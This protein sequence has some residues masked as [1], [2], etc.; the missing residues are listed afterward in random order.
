MGR[1]KEFQPVKSAA[2]GVGFGGGSSGFGA[3]ATGFGGGS[4]GF[5]GAAHPLAS[6]FSDEAIAADPLTAELQQHLKRLAKKDATTKRK[7]LAELIALVDDTTDDGVTRAIIALPQWCYMYA[8]LTND[9]TV[10][11]R[12]AAHTLM[13]LVARVVKAELEPHIPTV[14][15]RWW[16]AK[17][18]PRAEA[19][20]S[21]E[22]ALLATFP[23]RRINKALRLCHKPL[24]AELQEIFESSPQTVVDIKAVDGLDVAKEMYERQVFC[25]LLALGGFIEKVVEV[26][27]FDD[28]LRAGV[29][30]LLEPS[31]FWKLADSKFDEIRLGLLK[32]LPVLCKHMTSAVDGKLDRIAPSILGAMSDKTA[33]NYSAIWPAILQLVKT[34]PRSWSHV[35][36][37]TVVLPRMCSCLR[38]AAYGSWA[39]TYP[40]VLPWLSTL[41][42]SMVV[43]KLAGEICSALWFPVATGAVPSAVYQ[44]I[45][46]AWAEC[47]AHLI[48]SAQAGKESDSAGLSDADLANWASLPTTAKPNGKP[49]PEQ[50]AELKAAKLARNSFLQST[51][52]RLGVEWTPKLVQNRLEQMQRQVGSGEAE[53][54]PTAEALNDPCEDFYRVCLLEPSM[55]RLSEAHPKVIECWAAA[56]AKQIGT[57]PMLQPDHVERLLAE[58]AAVAIDAIGG[59][60]ADAA[61]AC[62]R[63]FVPLVRSFHRASSEVL[64]TRCALQLAQKVAYAVLEASSHDLPH[65]VTLNLLTGLAAL[66]LSFQHAMP[67]DG[68]STRNMIIKWLDRTVP[69]SPEQASVVELLSSYLG[70]IDDTSTAAAEWD[71]CVSAISDTENGSQI[72]LQLLQISID[73]DIPI[74]VGVPAVEN[75]ATS[76]SCLQ[77]LFGASGR[78]AAELLLLITPLLNTATVEQLMEWLTNSLERHSSEVGVALQNL[79]AVVDGLLATELPAGN[80]STKLHASRVQLLTQVFVLQV[81]VMCPVGGLG[82][83]A[84]HTSRVCAARCEELWSEHSSSLL[85]PA[86]GNVSGEEWC[87]VIPNLVEQILAMTLCT[88]FQA[89]HMKAAPIGACV[90]LASEL[91]ATSKFISPQC[92]QESLGIML[93]EL[94]PA[95]SS[96]YGT[97][98]QDSGVRWSRVLGFAVGVSSAVHPVD[99]FLGAEDDY[100]QWLLLELFLFG[101]LEPVRV[102]GGAEESLHDAVSSA[103]L[104]AECDLTEFW[105]SCCQG[106]LSLDGTNT[107][108]TPIPDF[109]LRTV[110]LAQEL[111][112]SAADGRFGGLLT[113]L[114]PDVGPSRQRIALADDLIHR[115]QAEV[116][117]PAQRVLLSSTDDEAGALYNASAVLYSLIPRLPQAWA[118]KITQE[119]V[120][121]V[122]GAG[123]IKSAQTLQSAATVLVAGHGL[124]AVAARSVFTHPADGITEPSEQAQFQ[125]QKRAAELIDSPEGSGDSD[126][127]DVNEIEE[128][129]QLPT[130]ATVRECI[131]SMLSQVRQ[132]AV[133]TTPHGH[134]ESNGQALYSLGVMR[135]M[136]SAIS[137]GIVDDGSVDANSCKEHWDFYITLA[138]RGA[139]P[140]TA[141]NNLCEWCTRSHMAGLELVAELLSKLPRLHTLLGQSRCEAFEDALTGVTYSQLVDEESSWSPGVWHALAA[142]LPVWTCPERTVVVGYTD[143]L[144]WQLANPHYTIR[145][146]VYQL[147]LRL[148]GAAMT[149][150]EAHDDDIEELAEEKDFSAHA[151][152]TRPELVPQALYNLIHH[153][154]PSHRDLL[155]IP[156]YM[157][158]WAIVLHMVSNAPPKLRAELVEMVTEARPGQADSS[159]SRLLSTLTSLL[160]L[161]TAGR[162]SSVRKLPASAGAHS[163]SIIH[164]GAGASEVA[165]ALFGCVLHQVR[166]VPFV[167]ISGCAALTSI[168][169]VSFLRCLESG[170]THFHAQTICWSRSMPRIW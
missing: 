71:S 168:D 34:F 129:G 65:M 57:R 124:A 7:A 96:S 138:I 143:E 46:T 41:P 55:E 97:T 77:R 132:T 75:L 95:L 100:R 157:F 2:R 10:Q 66:P 144:V 44:L 152:V 19:R 62:V 42:R 50:I 130:N 117:I 39:V 108:K 40:A 79:L 91:L 169:V 85:E 111:S 43:A 59:S 105:T 166:T 8:K 14:L 121:K 15:P 70:S 103:R 80:R 16:I 30:A 162:S 116:I 38:A 101:G 33:S 64:A 13:G 126:F 72:L 83:R 107:S 78:S 147:M 37:H 148:V 17:Y 154:A 3:A 120:E 32:L 52:D 167:K 48:G 128:P 98:R 146:E 123:T 5:G 12:E 26:D 4:A 153:D 87:K 1:R 82:N 122:C 150:I 159:A 158:A 53:P 31:A 18:D 115:L 9:A 131:R 88:E 60:D 84:L 21:A 155:T 29:S 93:K 164:E 27:K 161:E 56:I 54:E 119:C 139:M 68:S 102:A 110:I 163:L 136:S 22:T 140:F 151:P 67:A 73:T 156:A 23:G 36:V 170:S 125:R 35:D 63:W 94:V 135:A 141:E 61:A 127:E 149:D 11:V 47:A 109:V 58:V 45:A 113:T 118:W 89:D 137:A 160:P 20:Q 51:A 69:E 145:C 142:I 133:V 104:L 74:P 49:T 106:T 28:G 76:E 165:A 86:D 92:L 6:S 25:G 24:F 134:F 112:V 114:F 81:P 99:L 90:K